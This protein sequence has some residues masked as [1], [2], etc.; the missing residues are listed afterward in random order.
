MNGSSHPTQGSLPHGSRNCNKFYAPILRF[1]FAKSD[2]PKLGIAPPPPSDFGVPRFTNRL[3]LYDSEQLRSVLRRQIHITNRSEGLWPRPTNLVGGR[4]HFGPENLR[5]LVT[6]G[7]GFIGSALIHALNEAGIEQILV[8]DVLS[9]DEKWR[10]LS[11]LRF[12]D[13]VQADRF[14][15]NINH[16][17]RAYGNF[18]LVFHLGACSATTEK[19]AA[20]I[21]QTNFEYTKRLCRWALE[22]DARFVYASSAAT[23]GDGSRGMND[24]EENIDIYRPLNLY[25][26]SKQM[27]DQWAYRNGILDQIVGIKYFNVFGPNEYHKGEMRSVVCK[28]YEQIQSEGKI[29]LFRSYHPEYPDGGQMRDFIYVKDAVAMTIHLA[30]AP[31]GGLFNVGTGK[32]RTW[33]DLAHAI[34]AALGREPNI[35]YIDMPENLRGQYQYYTCAD[36]S[37]IRA[38]GYR[39]P[40][41]ELE[42]SV[43]DYVCNYLQP[44]LRLGDTP[45]KTAA[46]Y[47]GEPAAAFN[48]R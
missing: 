33:N 11:P 20:Y 45:P 44:G 38:S 24:R 19:D 39:T 25:G 17:S 41:M 43:R 8:T 12:E 47:R 14:L 13:Y 3:P 40:C 15:E 34:F 18:D 10:N 1:F 28:A 36:I 27:F 16:D 22:A 5:V 35:E 29:R 6:G 37:K 9:T 46:T 23:Y 26:Y 42:D 7:A 2:W 21:L 4:V 31:V 30:E 32:P 48:A